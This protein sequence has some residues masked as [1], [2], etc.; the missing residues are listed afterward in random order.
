M[1]RNGG[2]QLL[3]R[4]LGRRRV[5]LLLVAAWS[6]VEALPSL[7]CGVLIAVAVDRGFLAGRPWIGL[8]WLAAYGALVG[9]QVFAGRQLLPHLADVVE[10]VRD[11]LVEGVVAGALRRSVYGGDRPDIPAITRLTV[12][13][14]SIR[15][16]LSALLT[17]I[18]N[19]VLCAVAAAVG[20]ALLHPALA[21]VALVPVLVGTVAFVRLQRTL[22]E[23]KTAV[24]LAEEAIA[25]AVVAGIDGIRDIE[26]CRAHRRAAERIGE[27]IEAER[28][29]TARLARSEVARLVVL[30]ATADLPVLAVLAVAPFLIDSGHLTTGELIGAITYLSTAL[31]TATSALLGSVSMYALQLGVTL[32]RIAAH[33]AE[34]APPRGERLPNGYVVATQGLTFAYGSSSKSVIRDLTITVAEGEYVAVVGPSG[35]GKSTVAQLIGG[36]LQPV[37]GSVRVGGVPVADIEPRA[38][39]VMLLPQQAYV[40][41]GTLRENLTYLAPDASTADMD[42]ACA[43]IGLSDLRA[44]V[45]GY[46]ALVATAD[47]DLSEADRQLIALARVYLS[48]ARVVVLDEAT[49]F[50]DA[51]SEARAEH[52]FRERGGTLIVVAHRMSSALRA[53]RVLVIDADGAQ[54]GSHADL[55]ID[56]PRYR[57]L[58]G[59]WTGAP[60]SAV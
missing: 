10:P 55:L 59:Y 13:V 50:L 30:I 32:D 5:S 7:A 27:S 14:Q 41:A 20:L 52:A 11:A 1:N 4:E 45:G 21:V 37:A 58:V 24:L 15:G 9:L 18:R 28:L 43:A 38:D 54:I 51:T 19:V 16:L 36:L 56:S 31:R 57:D 44:R 48:P 53:D 3:R 40:F 35:A 26:A 60:A 17:D 23:R 12:Q 34:P 2:W 39:A 42:R 8:A 22:R 49:C 46:D 25:T 47:C 6:A 33:A 29:A